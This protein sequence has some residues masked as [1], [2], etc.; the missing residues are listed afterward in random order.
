M[1]NCWIPCSFYFPAPICSRLDITF[2]IDRSGSIH[3]HG[4]PS[5]QTVLNFTKDVSKHFIIIRLNKSKVWWLLRQLII[6]NPMRTSWHEKAFRMIVLFT[7]RRPRQNC[8][9]I[10]D[11]IFKCNFLEENLWLFIAISLEIVPRGTADNIPVLVQI[12]A[13]CR[14][15]DKPLSEAMMVRLLTH[16]CVTRLQWVMWRD[17]ICPSQ[18]VSI[19]QFWCVCL[20]IMKQLLNKELNGRW[21]ETP[22]HSYDVIDVIWSWSLN[23]SNLTT[24]SLPGF[25]IDRIK[26]HH[27]W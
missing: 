7:L 17:S 4:L 14:P 9:H 22:W 23:N 27:S 8:Y 3:Y 12:M 20:V 13:W 18:R 16:I 6:S 24:S 19:L 26:R 25:S 11:Y 2:A 15:G 10:A 1:E 21:S 5:F